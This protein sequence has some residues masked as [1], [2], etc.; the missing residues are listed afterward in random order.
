MTGFLAGLFGAGG[1][2]V[3]VPTLR[4]LGLEEDE[5]HATS[6]VVILPLALLSGM[7]YLGAGRFVIGDAVGFWPGGI[8]GA[9]VGALLLP[10]L[11]ARWLRKIFSAVILFSAIRLIFR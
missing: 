4:L 9:V 8:T 1:G 11:K 7:L 2:I 5:S 6:I 10:R 3:T